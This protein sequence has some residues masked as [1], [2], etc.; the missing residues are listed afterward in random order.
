[1]T[2]T[3]LAA[4]RTAPRLGGF[5]TTFIGLELRRM[6][7]NKRSLVFTFVMPSAFFLLFGSDSDFR[8]ERAG[9]GNVTAWIMISMALYGAMLATTSAGA[10]V[11]TERALGWSRQLRMTPLHPTAYI[12]VKATVAMAM[13][14]IA[15]VPVLVVGTL[16]GADLPFG[17]LVACAAIGWLCSAV[18]A[19]FGLFMGYLLPSENVMQLLGPSLALLAFAGGLFVPLSQMGHVFGD[20]AKFTPAYGVGELAR[21]PFGD[22]DDLGWAAL[23]VALWLVVFVA[24]AAWRMSR[25]TQRV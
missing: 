13:G 25:D 6:L 7:R 16:R 5:S 18:F 24:G 8:T 15:I 1:M 14:L 22:H 2:S 17:R 4:A 19:A 3:A 11:A 9:H 21:A 20:I 10:Q 12:A 23:N